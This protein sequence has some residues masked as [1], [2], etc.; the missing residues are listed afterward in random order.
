M[1]ETPRVAFDGNGTL[2]LAGPDGPLALRWRR[3]V[4]ARRLCLR[5]GAKGLELVVPQAAPLAEAGAFAAGHAGWIARQL[6]RTPA[7]ALVG[8]GAAVPYLGTEL[9]IVHRTDRLAR[10]PAGER[11]AWCAGGALHVRGESAHLPRRV[12][13]FLRAEAKARLT[14]LAREKGALLGRQPSRIT[15]RDTASRWG[16]CSTS[17][18]L[19]F[20]WRL[21]M[22][23][24]WVLDYVA[25]HEVAHLRHMNHGPR[26]WRACCG[27][28]APGEA[29]PRQVVER[30]RSWLR[31][32]GP[33]LHAV[34]FR[35]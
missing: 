23:P 1:H 26:F 11:V 3:S 9:T 17:G 8:P 7:A 12:E 21:V 32:N 33:A 20:S 24:P 6:A 4:R 2:S 35:P 13:D 22:T 16:S 10:G 14:A 28:L 34:R 30:A 25:A 29:A 15:V 5:T 18:A 19:S 31:Q 27:L